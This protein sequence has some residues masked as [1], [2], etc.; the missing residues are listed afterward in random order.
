MVLGGSMGYAP[1]NTAGTH[2][3]KSFCIM[4]TTHEKRVRTEMHH[5]I[6]PNHPQSGATFE[7]RFQIFFQLPE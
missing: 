2:S 3:Q 7:A 5:P 1:G 4:G 6:Q